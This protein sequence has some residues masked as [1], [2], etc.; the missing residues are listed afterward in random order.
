MG[1]CD[2]RPLI[3]AA[4]RG[5]SISLSPLPASNVMA[6]LFL[7]PKGS[8]FHFRQHISY[9]SFGNHGQPGDFPSLSTQERSSPFQKH[10]PL[11]SP[12]WAGSP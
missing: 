2:A 11:V 5:A 9:I 6:G 8:N 1:G 3:A 12:L 7:L 10:Q 4:P